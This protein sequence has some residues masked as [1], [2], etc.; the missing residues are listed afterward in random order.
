MIID[1]P[2]EVTSPIKWPWESIH[3]FPT[4]PSFH[5]NVPQPIYPLGLRS[6]QLQSSHR[7]EKWL[8]GEWRSPLAYKGRWPTSLHLS[9]QTFSLVLTI[10]HVRS[11]TSSIQFTS[12]NH[13][14][15]QPSLAVQLTTS[16]HVSLCVS[17]PLQICED[18]CLFWSTPTASDQGATSLWK[19]C[20][21]DEVWHPVQLHR[22]K[23]GEG[24]L[25]TSCKEQPNLYILIWRLDF[26]FP[27]T[28]W[29]CCLLFGLR[30]ATT[31]PTPLRILSCR[32][33]P[34]LDFSPQ[35]VFALLMIANQPHICMLFHVIPA[36]CANPF[37]F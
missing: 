4:Q 33:A 9:G 32:C 21:P 18:H 12:E 19:C 17:A 2:E 27:T 15:V 16:Y 26:F 30:S 36:V 11:S 29:D 24:S 22:P 23:A 8:D 28:V 6:A 10:S 13:P 31:L 37:K 1:L 5:E 14:V 3:S 7:E 25:N 34:W 20:V 35:L